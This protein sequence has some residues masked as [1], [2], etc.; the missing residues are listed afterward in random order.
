M[1]GL[2]KIFGNGIFQA[3]KEPRNRSVE[4]IF[5]RFTFHPFYSSEGFLDIL[6]EMLDEN[7]RFSF[8]Q[9]IESVLGSVDFQKSVDDENDEKDSGEDPEID[10]GETSFYLILILDQNKPSRFP[11]RLLLQ[12][13]GFPRMHR[14]H[15]SGSIHHLSE[16]G[17]FLFRTP[18]L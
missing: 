7:G 2:E 17:E 15:G 13:K 6:L 14:S 5:P 1:E 10:Q 9:E 8:Q 12:R 3:E 4:R 11:S 18:L 16:K